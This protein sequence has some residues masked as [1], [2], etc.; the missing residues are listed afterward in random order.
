MTRKEAIMEVLN[1]L[2]CM[3]SSD[4]V[5]IHNEY[6]ESSNYLDDRIY[7]FYELDD[8]C[9]NMTPTEIINTYGELSGCDYFTANVY[10]EPCEPYTYVDCKDIA[11]F[12]IDNEDCLYNTEIQDIIDEYLESLDNEEEEDEE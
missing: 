7:E 12:C 3:D 5:Y 10:I 4:L 1:I 9:Y 11:K 8:L 6:C 2:E